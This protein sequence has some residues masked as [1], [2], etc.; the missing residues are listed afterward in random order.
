VPDPVELVE[1]ADTADAAPASCT[2]VRVDV[3]TDLGCPWCYVG[4]HRLTAAVEAVRT[5]GVEAQVVLHSFELHPE[6]PAGT[7]EPVLQVAS[8]VHGVPAA[9]AR[10]MEEGMARQARSEGLAFTV[11][12]PVA[13]TFDVHRLLQLAD[14]HG[15]GE[16]FFADVQGQYFAGRLDP[17]DHAALT[18]AAARH[19]IP[20]ADAR[21]V[22]ASAEHA[23]AVRADQAQA[24]ALGITGVPFAVVGGR[25]AV[26]G[27]QSVEAY[28]D[29]L[30]R[31]AAQVQA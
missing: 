24:R 2:G 31:A 6:W 20:E 1:S 23:G 25:Y 8:R 22:L 10:A 21:R 9:Q 26:A 29:V 18:A 28:A 14:R 16:A 13:N 7:S 27:A 12:R 3:W 17:T 4:K 15:A 11:D 30:T 19:G 5:D